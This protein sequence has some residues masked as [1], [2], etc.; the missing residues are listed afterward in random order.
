MMPP[1][2]GWYLWALPF[3]IIYQIKTDINGKLLI[4]LF[5]IL[6]ILI[7]FPNDAFSKITFLDNI[8]IYNTNLINS[9][10]QNLIYTFFISLGVLIAIRLYRETIQNNDYYK[11]KRKAFTIGITGG[12][13][14]G[15]NTLTKSIIDLIG[16]HSFITIKETDYVKW[17][18]FKKESKNNK[19]L[20]INSNDLLKLNS[21]LEL[22]LD[23]D[24][25]NRKEINNSLT[26]YQNI[27]S[28]EKDFI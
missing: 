21:D 1:S 22:I 25:I 2:P 11:L 7:I 10:S 17:T 13:S 5:T 24:I 19:I 12:P 9:I 3:L 8:F 26:K 14:S 6:P 28:L 16:N 18:G 23:K 15:K 4:S 27:N 20:N